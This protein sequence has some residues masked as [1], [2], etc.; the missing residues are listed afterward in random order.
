MD[1]KIV[2]GY[3]GVFPGEFRIWDGQQTI[4]KLNFIADNGFSQTGISFKEIEDE[5]VASEA[6][7]I[8]AKRGIEV[9][10]HPHLTDVFGNDIDSVK[11]EID[12]FTEKVAKYKSSL[13]TPMITYCVGPYHRFMKDIPLARQMERLKDLFTP[14]A[15]SCTEMGC[16]LAIENH[17]DYYASDLVALCKEVK[18]LWILFDSGNCYLIGEKPILAVKEASK[19]I[20]GTHLKD[21]F[22]APNLKNLSFELKGAAL[23]DGDVGIREVYNEIVANSQA[24][25]INFQWELIPP[26]D[27]DA[28]IT[29]Q[30]S[31]DF[32]KTL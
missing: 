8:I 11:R 27:I 26:K 22:V 1:K 5:S 12:E 25:K 3:A 7:E 31:W 24:K 18:D 29:L 19:Y 28:F 16:P 6:F 21:H 15:K 9:S 20:L 30:K 10:I 13:N 32:I 2:W 17:G 23:G 4:N 14:L